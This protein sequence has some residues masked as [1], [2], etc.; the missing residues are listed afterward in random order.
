[1]ITIEPR[2]SRRAEKYRLAAEVH[3]RGLSSATMR[4]LLTYKPGQLKRMI[5]RA[6]ESEATA[7]E[8]VQ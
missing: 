8:N 5:R 6:D 1:M 7:K 4:V 2:D 3:A